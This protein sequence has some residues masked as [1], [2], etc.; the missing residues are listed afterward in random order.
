MVILKSKFFWIC[1]IFTVC[2]AIF[3]GVVVHRA[4]QPLPVIKVYKAVELPQ[5]RTPEVPAEPLM[6][7]SASA[8]TAPVDWRRRDFSQFPETDTTDTFTQDALPPADVD[9]TTVSHLNTEVDAVADAETDAVASFAAE[10]LAEIRIQLPQLLQDRLDLLD[11]VEELAPS[12][13]APPELSPVRD[14]LDEESVQLRRTIFELGNDYLT[15][16]EGDFSP[17][18]PGGEFY[19]LLRLNHMGFRKAVE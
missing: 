14:K 10:R 16:S 19:E 5:R 12:N 6:S 18:Q 2:A 17:F 7:D 3:L 1:T 15:Y 11:R 13:G 8:E 9:P 4:N